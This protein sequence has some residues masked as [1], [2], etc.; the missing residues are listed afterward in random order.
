MRGIRPE[1]YRPNYFESQSLRLTEIRIRD[2]SETEWRLRQV[3]LNQ[4]NLAHFH[5]ST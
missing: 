3:K 5:L 1:G 4:N 2:F